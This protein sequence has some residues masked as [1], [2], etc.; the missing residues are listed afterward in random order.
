MDLK[1]Q[2]DI[3]PLIVGD[4]NTLF[5]PIDRSFGQKKGEIPEKT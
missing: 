4:F 2:V 5:S 1:T 3:S